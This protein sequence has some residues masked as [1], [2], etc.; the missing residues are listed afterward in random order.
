MRSWIGAVVLCGIWASA[1]HAWD[2]GAVAMPGNANQ[3]CAIQQTG[4]VGVSFNNVLVTKPAL[5]VSGYRQCQ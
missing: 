1:A 4:Q 2:K 3:S 5:N